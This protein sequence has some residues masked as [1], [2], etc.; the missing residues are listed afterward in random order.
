MSTKTW[1][2]SSQSGLEAISTKNLA[3]LSC[4]KALSK[5]SLIQNKSFNV[6]KGDK[7][8]YVVGHQFMDIETKMKVVWLQYNQSWEDTIELTKDDDSVGVRN[9]PWV[10]VVIQHKG[11][12]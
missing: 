6:A 11:D 8:A 12:D 9:H 1:R 10:F 2:Q 3:S 4:L 5:A 7:V